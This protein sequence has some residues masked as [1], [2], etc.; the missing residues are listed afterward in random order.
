MKFSLMFLLASMWA[1]PIHPAEEGSAGE[2]RSYGGDAGGSKYSPLEQINKKN[3]AQLREAWVYDTGDVSDGTTYPTRSAFEA[4][5]LVVD[6]V[7]YVTTPFCRLIALDPETGTKLWDFDPKIDKTIARNLFLSR[8]VSYWRNGKTRRIFL[9]DLDGRLFSI[10]AASGKLDTK[11]GRRGIKDI[12]SPDPANC[13]YGLAAS[14]R[15]DA[16]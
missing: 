5:P 2:W 11:F 15:G 14:L 4:T 9:G 13:N 8:G 1:L 12:E 10:D 6:G 16:A 7:M 3:V